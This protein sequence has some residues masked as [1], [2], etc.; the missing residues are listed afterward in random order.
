MMK[1]SA[2]LF[3]VLAAL[4][5]LWPQARAAAE[6]TFMPQW[7]PQSQFAGFYLAESK[8][9]FAEEGLNIRIRH[10]SENQSEDTIRCAES[11]KADIVG[12]MLENA[13]E[14]RERGLRLVNIMQVLQGNGLACVSRKPLRTAED[15]N[16][17]RVAW[18]KSLNPVYPLVISRER[19]PETE[20]IEAVNGNNLY[21]YKAVDAVLVYTYSELPRLRLSMGEI[22]QEN[23]LDFSADGWA[24]PGDGIYV[25]EAFYEAHKS[26]LRAFV[27]ACKRGW[28]YARAHPEEALN[29]TEQYRNKAHLATNR[30]FQ[31]MML[32][33]YLR[34]QENPAT[35]RADFALPTRE[36]FEQ[37][38][39]VLQRMGALHSDVRY[40]EVFRP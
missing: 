22:P 1:R 2:V 10:I 32:E 31:R 6:M 19:A 38:V 39:H 28:E 27:R 8:G 11:G 12:C 15:L 9:F 21:I 16:G 37:C 26:E 23:V 40:E 24:I 13:V 3:S 34:L 5:C 14:A 17:L 7:I 35:G 33:E 36:Q 29:A 4:F 30:V 25:T 18:W 20:W